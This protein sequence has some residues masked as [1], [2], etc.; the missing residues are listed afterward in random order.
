MSSTDFGE[1]GGKSR[2]STTRRERLLTKNNNTIEVN[3]LKC[4]FDVTKY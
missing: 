2:D 3:E 4:V 1:D